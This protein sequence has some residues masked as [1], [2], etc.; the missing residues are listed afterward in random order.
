MS[1]SLSRARACTSALSMPSTPSRDSATSFARECHISPTTGIT[2]EDDPTPGPAPGVRG[3]MS[4]GTIKIPDPRP[5]L[6]VGGRL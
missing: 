4:F 5:R 1:A 2:S 6:L 3:R